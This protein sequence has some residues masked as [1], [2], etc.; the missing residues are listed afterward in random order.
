MSLLNSLI[1]RRLSL[2]GVEETTETTTVQ[3]EPSSEPGAVEVSSTTDSQTQPAVE[4]AA[5]PTAAV[6]VD[7]VTETEPETDLVDQKLEEVRAEVETAAD[8]RA[9]LEKATDVTERLDSVVTTMESLIER[10]YASATEV[11]L[12]KHR[13]TRLLESIEVPFVEL[14][15]ESY[16]SEEG[17]LE[18]L[19]LTKES[20]KET[21][22][23]IKDAVV[24]GTKRVVSRIANAL[25]AL[26]DVNHDA[27]MRSEALLKQASA[28]A[29]KVPANEKIAL[30][31]RHHR[32]LSDSEGKELDPVKVASELVKF[33][34][35]FTGSFATELGKLTETSPIPTLHIPAGLPASPTIRVEKDP[36]AGYEVLVFEEHFAKTSSAGQTKA[37][38]GKEIEAVARAVHDSV[39]ALKTDWIGAMLMQE[40]KD[41]ID[42]RDELTSSLLD[43]C[44]YIQHL[45][46]VLCRVAELSV[47]NLKDAE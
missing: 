34:K 6:E 32:Y 41:G 5:E 9:D 10:G 7:P 35:A 42:R 14:S 33:T 12:L 28:I 23:K 36:H 37:L 1:N 46:S 8:E 13:G 11:K 27:L 24:E 19:T 44:F 43:V 22:S 15:T 30:A 29:G 21:A 39:T 31:Y 20:F 26:V 16:N 40:D 47:K 3:V 45:H 18:T 2:E 17:R 4:P 25:R 38:S